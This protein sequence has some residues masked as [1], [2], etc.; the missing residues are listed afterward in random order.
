MPI[1]LIRMLIEK[2][3][4]YTRQLEYFIAA[5]LIFREISYEEGPFLLVVWSLLQVVLVTLCFTDIRCKSDFPLFFNRCAVQLSHLSLG[6]P[7]RLLTH[8]REREFHAAT[9]TPDWLRASSNHQCWPL[10]QFQGSAALHF[11]FFN[12]IWGIQYYILW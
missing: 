10:R 1:S 3:Y 7:S 8:H 5:P 6:R 12:I 9:G 11:W 4:Y 2:R